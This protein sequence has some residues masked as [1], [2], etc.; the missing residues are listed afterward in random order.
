MS[1]EDIRG[2][3]QASLDPHGHPSELEDHLIARISILCMV[4]SLWIES[5]SSSLLDGDIQFPPD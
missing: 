2:F 1:I 5:I 4:I 3:V